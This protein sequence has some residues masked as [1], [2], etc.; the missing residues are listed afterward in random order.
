MMPFSGVTTALLSPFKNDRLD[1]SSLERVIKDQLKNGIHGFVVNGTTAESPVLTVEEQNELFPFVKS[2]CEKRA[3]V[4]MGTGCN[5]TRKTIENSQRAERLGAQA[6]LVVVPYY[7]KP[8]QRGLV[9]HFKAVA[10]NVTIP[11]ILYNVPSRT[12]TSLSVESI[13]ELSSHKRIIGIKEASGDIEFAKKILAGVS[14]EFLLLSGDDGTYPAF[15][16]AGGHG[17]ISV[18]SHVLPAKMGEWFRNIKQENKGPLDFQNYLNLI[19]LL[20]CEANPIPLKAAMQMMGLIE[21]SSL[22]LPLIEMSTE[23]RQKLKTEMQR[24]G[25]LA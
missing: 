2:F 23:N 15:L 18:L 20:F 19:G 13:L 11:V 12:I 22:R 14:K 17:T 10:D 16:E 9:E 21:F 1:F 3:H 24:L 25:M 5:N 6:V 4:I 7:N 8:P